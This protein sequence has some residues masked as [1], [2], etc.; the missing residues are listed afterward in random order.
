[1][2]VVFSD[3]IITADE[4]LTLAYTAL[5]PVRVAYQIVYRRDGSWRFDEAELVYDEAERFTAFGD[6]AGAIMPG[7]KERVITL[8]QTAD[9]LYGYVLVQVLSLE[10][11]RL[12][13]QTG[14]VITVTP[15][16]GQLDPRRGDAGC[17][18]A[19]GGR[20][21]AGFRYALAALR[22]ERDGG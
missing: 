5:R 3:D 6:L 22:A 19:C 2:D 11:G 1:M 21:A 13:M 15:P 7:R 20:G 8:K 16:A 14:H 17:V 12:T 10:N 9:D 4:T 18:Q